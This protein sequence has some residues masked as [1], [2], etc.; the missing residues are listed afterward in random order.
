MLILE[1]IVDVPSVDQCSVATLQI[2]QEAEQVTIVDWHEKL[3]QVKVESLYMHS[4]V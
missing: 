4:L 2:S 1:L 3:L